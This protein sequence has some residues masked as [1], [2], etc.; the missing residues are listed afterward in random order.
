MPRA[1][2][3]LAR[4]GM[5]LYIDEPANLKGQSLYVLMFEGERTKAISY[6]TEKSVPISTSAKRGNVL[7]HGGHVVII[8]YIN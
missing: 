8:L 2:D 6:T 1:F 7:A 5:S 3:V 4:Y